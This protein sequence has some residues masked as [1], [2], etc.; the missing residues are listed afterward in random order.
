MAFIEPFILLGVSTFSHLR[1]TFIIVLGL[2][3][4]CLVE[5]VQCTVHSQYAVYCGV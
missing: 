2:D 3:H 5:N 1:E 4:L